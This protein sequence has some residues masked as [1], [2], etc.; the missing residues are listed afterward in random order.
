MV[1]ANSP[2]LQR[3]AGGLEAGGGG[4]QGDVS[5][6]HGSLQDGQSATFES[7]MPVGFAVFHAVHVAI[8][9]AEQFCRAV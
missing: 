1:D 3:Y 5:W 7:G 6:N 8:A 9:K 4:L 2:A